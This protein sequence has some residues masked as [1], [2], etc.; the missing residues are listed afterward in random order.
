LDDRYSTSLHHGHCTGTGV[1]VLMTLVMYRSSDGEKTATKRVFRSPVLAALLSCAALDRSSE[2][3]HNND[4]CSLVSGG[5]DPNLA[6]T[7]EREFRLIQDGHGQHSRPRGGSSLYWMC[8]HDRSLPTESHT[9]TEVRIRRY[10]VYF[11]VA[12]PCS[13]AEVASEWRRALGERRSGEGVWRA[14]YVQ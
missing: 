7:W 8:F 3:H 1:R 14:M 5:L 6:G 12:W 9:R 11:H 10:D 13:D 4:R 2:S